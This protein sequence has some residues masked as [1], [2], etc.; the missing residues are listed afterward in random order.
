[1]PVVLI[2]LA[3]ALPCVT[4][5]HD[6]ADIDWP[7]LAWSLPARV[8]GTAV[9]VWVVAQFSHRQLGIAVGVVVLLAVLLTW[10]LF[11][12]PITRSSLGVAGFVSGIG[13]FW[14]AA[15]ISASPW[16]RR[17]VT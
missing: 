5:V 3:L 2:I 14:G 4:L 6:H 11:T 16:S 1:M 8:A 17:S 10:R 9:G 15:A 12:V 13:L 7:G